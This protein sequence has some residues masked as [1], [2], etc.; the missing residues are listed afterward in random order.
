MSAVLDQPAQI[1]AW[2]FLSRVSQLALEL[3]TGLNTSSR[4]SVYKVIRGQIIPEDMLPAR[5]TK[6]NKAL[7]LAMLLH[8]QDSSPTIDLA[9]TT[10][11]EVLAEEGWV[12]T[13]A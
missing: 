7:A 8:D 9:R 12:I 6:Q 13:I 5:A 2:V 4:G 3:K 1:N 11:A 10:L